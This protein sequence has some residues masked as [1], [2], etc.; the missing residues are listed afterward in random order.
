M[1]LTQYRSRSQRRRRQKPAPRQN[2][3]ERHRFP[4]SF[5]ITPL[6]RHRL[7]PLRPLMRRVAKWSTKKR[8][9]IASHSSLAYS[10]LARHKTPPSLDCGKRLTPLFSLIATAFHRYSGPRYA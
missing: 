6:V 7:L 3:A 2:L 1:R 4:A 8:T 5:Q 10:S 9:A